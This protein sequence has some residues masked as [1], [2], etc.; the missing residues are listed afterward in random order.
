MERLGERRS[1]W[2]HIDIPDA[3]PLNQDEDCDVCVVGAGISGLTTAYFLAKQGRSVIV[4]DN[5]SIGG[6]QTCRTSAHLSYVLDDRFY[7]MER[8][9]GLE[10]V[11]LAVESHKA[12]IDII[13]NIC[14]NENID[15]DFL[16]VAG[17][18]FANSSRESTEIQKE[19]ECVQR[20]E[21]DGV[22]YM[23]QTPFLK[24][25]GGPCL[26]FPSAAQFHPLKYLRGL[27]KA[28][29]GMGVRI[30]TQTRVQSVISDENVRISTNANRHVFA[31]QAVVATNS[32]IND[33]FVIHTKQAP[34]RTY[35]IA[36]LIPAGT[37]SL[38]LFW[39]SQDPYHYVR[40]QPLSEE[41]S[42]SYGGT[43][44]ERFD[45]LIV[46]GEDHKTGHKESAGQRYQRLHKWTL[47]NFPQLNKVVYQ[48]SGQVLETFDGL[49]FIG[50][51]PFDENVFIITGD[52]GMGLTHGTIGG[53]LVSDLI[54]DVENPWS[55][56][57]DPSRVAN[58]TGRLKAYIS[59]GAHT[60]ADYGQW[61]WRGRRK[62]ETPLGFEEGSILE[63]DGKRVAAYRDAE[64]ELHLMSP[65]CPHLGGMLHWNSSEKTWDCPIHGSSFQACGEAISGPAT[66][67]LAKII[68][69]HIEKAS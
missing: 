69:Q 25:A 19:F 50:R 53:M 67:N 1:V 58:N 43:R 62:G 12:A 61:L 66:E 59:E 34:Y 42:L 36:C 54:N 64:G 4:L 57:Y 24:K 21:L 8:M 3:D 47:K 46:G 33:R 49:A 63:I 65:V 15:C 11:K 28:L 56:I 32:P 20:L 48:W 26:R 60:L 16:R 29:M 41:E 39:D 45:L 44:T 55:K 14:L 23:P 2:M 9:F 38:A 22:E 35:V 51:N 6:G 10:G 68:E 18:L 13:E 5:Q 37:V 30:Y 17:Y 7:L 52:S 40:V 31:D 27:S